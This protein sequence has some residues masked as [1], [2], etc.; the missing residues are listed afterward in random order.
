[1]AVGQRQEG[2]PSNLRQELRDLRL[3]KDKDQ[4]LNGRP[5]TG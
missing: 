2:H 4:V 5:R 1:M 3:R